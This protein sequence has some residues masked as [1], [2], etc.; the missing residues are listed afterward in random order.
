MRM[1]H[2]VAVLAAGAGGL[3]WLATLVPPVWV[4]AAAGWCW[5]VALGS[6]AA[7]LWWTRFRA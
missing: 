4:R 1:P 7:G 3:L 5:G 6:W 2:V